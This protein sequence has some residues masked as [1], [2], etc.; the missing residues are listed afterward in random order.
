[1]CRLRPA[2][3]VSPSNG[4]LEKDQLAYNSTAPVLV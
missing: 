1:M 3:D 4:P 2:T